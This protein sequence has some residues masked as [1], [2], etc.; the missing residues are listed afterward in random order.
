[1]KV[2]MLL[3]C[4]IMIRIAPKLMIAATRVQIAQ[5]TLRSTIELFSMFAP[6]MHKIKQ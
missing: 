6:V 4:F 5:P 1:M 3:A 2:M